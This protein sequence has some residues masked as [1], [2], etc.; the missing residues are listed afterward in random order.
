M[1]EGKEE[2]LLKLHELTKREKQIIRDKENSAATY[3]EEIKMIKQ[4]TKDV[5]RDLE[6]LETV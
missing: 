1:L 4:E 3:N 6:K 5:L 2:L